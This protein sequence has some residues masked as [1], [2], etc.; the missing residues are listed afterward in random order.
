MEQMTPR[1]SSP[2]DL[3][4]AGRPFSRVLVQTN[5]R[6]FLREP[7]TPNIYSS[8]RALSG[9]SSKVLHQK[10]ILPDL[11]LKKSTLQIPGFAG[12]AGTP[13]HP[14]SYVTNNNFAL[15]SPPIKGE[16]IESMLCK[17]CFCRI[18]VVAPIYQVYFVQPSHCGCIIRAQVC[19]HFYNCIPGLCDV[20][21]CA[22]ISQTHD[23]D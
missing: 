11:K 2:Q 23:G 8:P 3:I 10:M 5:S 13:T 18:K 17:M 22:S 12:E 9:T 19:F 1:T 7:C 4:R 15:Q 6:L 21:R 20:F 16:G 14:A